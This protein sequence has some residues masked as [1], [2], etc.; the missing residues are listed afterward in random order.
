MNSKTDSDM[1][2]LRS[3]NTHFWDDDYIAE[4]P[5]LEKLLFLYLL[6]C[7]ATNIAGVY[8]LT[9][10]LMLFHTGL[11]SEQIDAALARFKAN[12][13]VLYVDNYII[14]VNHLKNQK[15]NTNMLRARDAIIK[16]LPVAVLKAF[17]SVSKPSEAFVQ[18][19]DEDETKDK[20][21]GKATI[22]QRAQGFRID[23]FAPE[24]KVKYGAAM[25]E[26]FYAY[27][28]EPN[29]SGKKMRMELQPTWKL[30]GRLATWYGKEMN[31]KTGSQRI[32]RET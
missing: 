30:A 21:E 11:T 6:T 1:A 3:V 25:L 26:A 15:L 32:Y 19:K 28:S 31:R 16:A 14:M 4:L 2:K 20:P 18:V 13:K 7:P 17:E 27:W 29:R 5:P 9:R 8:E 10:R 12:T 23:V 24:N 22:E